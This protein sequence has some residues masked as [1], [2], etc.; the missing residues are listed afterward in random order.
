MEYFIVSQKHWPQLLPRI[1]HKVHQI[2][3]KEQMEP[4]LKEYLRT[5]LNNI[6]FSH[7]V[8]AAILGDRKKEGAAMLVDQSSLRGIGVIT[9]SSG[10]GTETRLLGHFPLY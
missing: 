4:N 6:S 2:L 5:L 8:M 10:F 7:D 9:V 3:K 1:D